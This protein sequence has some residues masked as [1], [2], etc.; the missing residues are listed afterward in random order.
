M[1]ECKESP[2]RIFSLSAPE[3]EETSCNYKS[4]D[5]MRELYQ[6]IYIKKNIFQLNESACLFVPDFSVIFCGPF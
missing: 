2:R 4:N 3:I 6:K 1:G 5:D